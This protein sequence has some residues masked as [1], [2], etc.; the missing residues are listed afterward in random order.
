MDHSLCD[1]S[2]LSALG[3]ATL[4]V[5][6]G[7]VSVSL[8][9]SLRETPKRTNSS[10]ASVASSVDNSQALPARTEEAP[11]HFLA[12]PLNL[13]RLTKNADLIII[14]RINSIRNRGRATATLGIE[15][16]VKGRR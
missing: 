16:V 5:A 7:I 15:K 10:A 6:L 13:E 12:D 14:G 11:N 4:L 3:V 8:S 1:A 9:G 2:P